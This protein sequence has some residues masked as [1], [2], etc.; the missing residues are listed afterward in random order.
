MTFGGLNADCSNDCGSVP[1][2]NLPGSGGLPYRSI[3][4]PRR[5]WSMVCFASASS[6]AWL[7]NSS[8]KSVYAMTVVLWSCR[9]E[10]YLLRYSRSWDETS[11]VIELANEGSRANHGIEAH[12]FCLPIGDK[13][14]VAAC[15]GPLLDNFGWLLDLDRFV[16]IV[17]LNCSTFRECGLLCEVNGPSSRFSELDWWLCS[18]VD[19]GGDERFEDI[20]LKRL[21]NNIIGSANWSLNYFFTRTN[22]FGDL[23]VRYTGEW[24]YYYVDGKRRMSWT[25]RWPWQTIKYS[26]KYRTKRWKWFWWLW[27][28]SRLSWFLCSF[29]WWRLIRVQNEMTKCNK[30]VTKSQFY[31]GGVQVANFKLFR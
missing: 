6:F 3:V 9:S 17:S 20:T 21:L 18:V 8:C 24:V 2:I 4:A 23:S 31:T 7:V 1:C 15:D 11:E 22:F 14:V 25:W 10:R 19:S 28:L 13:L 12:L 27:L 29:I 16:S 26:F 30:T 5:N